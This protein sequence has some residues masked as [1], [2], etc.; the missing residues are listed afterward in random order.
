MSLTNTQYDAIMREYYDIRAKNKLISEQRRD[1]ID[2]LCPEYS[3]ISGQIGELS[4]NAA[5]AR[6]SKKGFAADADDYRSKLLAL[7]ERQAALL[8]S[9]SKPAG[10]LEPVFTCS[11]CKDTGYIGKNK[12]ECFKKRELE[13]L[14]RDSNL[15]NMVGSFTFEDFDLSL[16]S[17]SDIDNVT[18]K[19]SRDYAR[20]ALAAA[21]ELV[22]DFERA[23]GNLFIYGNTGLGKTFLSTCIASALIKTTHSVVYVTATEL[24]NKLNTFDD[25]VD[26]S[27]LL[28]C[29]LL[30]IDDLG[31]EYKSQVSLSKLFYCLN[32]RLLRRKSCVISTNLDLKAIRD[33]YSERIFSRIISNYKIIKLFGKDI[34]T[35]G[36]L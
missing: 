33:Y 10:Y 19:T 21:R 12:C 27:P 13:I 2:A 23:P 8:E 26:A 28:E 7:K 3:R 11:L 22:D 9:L 32:E 5:S 24:M 34:R 17:E 20:T 30:I 29:D 14:F 6:L 15:K 16:Y 35:L 25:D 36:L 4:V 18:G 1:E 31:T